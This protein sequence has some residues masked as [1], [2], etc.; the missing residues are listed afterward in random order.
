MATFSNLVRRGSWTLVVLGC[1]T[2]AAACGGSGSG[3]SASSTTYVANISSGDTDTVIQLV[4]FSDDGSGSPVDKLLD[5]EILG[6]GVAPFIAGRGRVPDPEADVP[7][8]CL[9][10]YELG[11]D[12]AMPCWAD[13]VLAEVQRMAA[14]RGITPSEITVIADVSYVPASLPAESASG[15]LFALFDS[16]AE[17]KGF[18]SA[19]VV[20]ESELPAAP[21][22]AASAG[23]YNFNQTLDL[24]LIHI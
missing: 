17:E 24:S 16:Y 15:G 12:R 9:D 7:A 11:L 4:R 8:Y 5:T 22:V 20:E 2:A 13:P 3:D 18:E 21:A 23:A 19:I 14:V 6:Y 1:L 10:S